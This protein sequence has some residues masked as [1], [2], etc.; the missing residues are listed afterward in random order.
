M[1]RYGLAVGIAALVLAGSGAL[2]RLCGGVGRVAAAELPAVSAVSGDAAC[3]RCHGAIAANYAKTAMARGSGAARD[4]LLTGG[5]THAP[6]GIRYTVKRR[7]AEPILQYERVLPGTGHALKGEQ[8]LQYFVGS[9]TRGRTYLFE[10]NGQWFEAPINWYAKRAV[11]DMAPA[12]ESAATM[13]FT[14]PVDANCLHCH[15]TG[16]ATT[17]QGVRNALGAQPFAQGG[18]GCSSCHGDSS[19]H[20]ASGGRLPT[21]NPDKLSPVRRDSVCLQ[22]HLEGDAVV[23]RAG[24]SLSDFRAGDDLAADAVYFVNASSAKS[25]TRASSQYEAML[26]SACKRA[27]GDRLTCTTCHD[28]HSSPAPEE[29]VAFFRQRC[30]QCHT[31]ATM[32]TAHH[33]EQQDCAVCHMPTRKTSDISHEQLTD[34]DV[35]VYPRGAKSAGKLTMSDPFVASRTEL[36]AI[37]LAV[38]GDWAVDARERG[39]AYAHFAARGDAAAGER[40]LSLLRRA[41]FDHQADAAVHA[42]L[43][44]LL[45]ARH[46]TR[47]AQAEYRQALAADPTD[48]TAAADLAILEA[49]LGETGAAKSRLREV[50]AKDGAQS[51]AAL[52][53]ALLECGSGEKEDARAVV[54]QV[55]RMDPD[56]AQAHRFLEEGRFGTAVCSL[57]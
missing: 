42:A 1:G 37:D 38:V 13:P 22:C 39:L 52:D 40:A 43:G 18:I 20:V 3:A 21:L 33:P 46:E 47:E 14:M 32:A 29:R 51:T 26:R 57:R 25:Q 56:N 2:M 36:H 53:L 54:K 15:A 50:V 45:Q 12:F 9:N 23:Y 44:F 30:L 27:S 5:F 17:T 55:L 28:P 11:W 16:V 7:G 8:A 49:G 19:A 24:R 4:G 6:S 31:G 34:H 10:Q 48:S 35:E 41:E